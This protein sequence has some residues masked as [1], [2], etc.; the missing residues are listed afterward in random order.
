MNI[1]EHIG[2]A[3]LRLS[4]YKLKKIIAKYIEEAPLEAYQSTQL[5]KVVFM[6][7]LTHSVQRDS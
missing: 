4:T 2:L 6:Q 1:L 3:I 7:L 5:E